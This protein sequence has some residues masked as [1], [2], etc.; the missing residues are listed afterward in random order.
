MK[1]NLQLYSQKNLLSLIINNSTRGRHFENSIKKNLKLKNFK[2]PWSLDKYN[3]NFHRIFKKN[4]DHFP[5]VYNLRTHRT[6]SVPSNYKLRKP[7][8]A[9]SH[10]V[11]QQA[12]NNLE[13]RSFIIILRNRGWHEKAGKNGIKQGWGAAKKGGELRV[14]VVP[15][16]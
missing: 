12:S 15:A 7:H 4:L 16:G 13:R 9:K 5:R 2:K 8:N 1:R 14:V 6:R 3:C 11:Q 10:N